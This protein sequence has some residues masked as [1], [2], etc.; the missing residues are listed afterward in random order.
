MSGGALMELVA[1]GAQDVYLS[2]NPQVTFFK[3]LYKRHT[4]F[5]M[6]SVEAG[7]NG[8]VGFGKRVSLVVPRV[9]DLMG[10]VYLQVTLP[11]FTS[12][13]GDPETV[14]W[15]DEVG[16]FLINNVEI[17]IGGQVIDKHYGTWLSIWAALTVDKNKE[18]GYN[19]M[20]G[21]PR[22]TPQI[23]QPATE[24]YIPLQFSF[25]RSEG[26]S[27]P[28]IALQYHE[29]RFTVEFEQF[30][31]LLGTNGTATDPITPTLD[32]ARLYIDYF[33][34]DTEERRRFAQTSHE[35]LIEQLQFTGD[36]SLPNGS[37]GVKL[38][39]NHPV[40][41]LIWVCLSN[42]RVNNEYHVVETIG[43]TDY[44]INPVETAKL[45]FNGHDR[46]SARLGRY[47]GEVQPWQHHT[48]IPK[49]GI[50]VYS[51]ALYPELEQPS[52]TANFSRIDNSTLSI[53]LNTIAKG[54]DSPYA[55]I[56]AVNY[57]VLRI[58]SG[59]GGLAYSN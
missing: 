23:I 42:D 26:L 5:A 9:G 29:V 30:A 55:K 8:S 11:E 19:N 39:F 1:Y 35:Y 15:I 16:H 22:S 21:I 47:F 32:T 17:Q 27:I 37:F 24:L 13:T 4:N 3:Q 41:E 45:Q 52:G 43:T 34:L 51:F 33:F 54:E 14:A 36:E 31:N 10:R 53:T 7:F 57:N 38:N 46:F 20:I 6:Q 28:L 56:Y 40:K 49:A 48:N 18:E 25:C 50:N 58:M 2:G 12:T 59:M 44:N